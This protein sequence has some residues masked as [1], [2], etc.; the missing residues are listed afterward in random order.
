MRSGHAARVPAGPVRADAGPVPGDA[1]LPEALW[2]QVWFA[3]R[4]RPWSSLALVPAH[5]GT[6]ALFIAEALVSVGGLHGERPVKLLDAERARLPDV[7][8]VL[9]SLDAIVGREEVAVLAVD[10]PGDQA[11]SIPIARA[12][13][14]AILVVP[15]GASR[16]RDARRAM[17][18]VGRD[19]FIGAVTLALEKK[20]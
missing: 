16:F 12:A 9:E 14:A 19:R 8:R 17:D 15:L 6:S 5:P 7:G 2:Q 3:A 10:G 4:R 13:D 11:A 1:A 18:L 20:S